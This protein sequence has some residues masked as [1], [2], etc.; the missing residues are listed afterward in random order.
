MIVTQLQIASL[1][2]YKIKNQLLGLNSRF[3]RSLSAAQRRYRH[4][5]YRY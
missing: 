1:T 5:F 4:R 2:T 3:Y